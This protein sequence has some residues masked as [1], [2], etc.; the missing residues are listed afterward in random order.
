ML[1]DISHLFVRIASEIMFG[2]DQIV[3]VS[4]VIKSG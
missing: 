3:V 2:G 1:L 4:E